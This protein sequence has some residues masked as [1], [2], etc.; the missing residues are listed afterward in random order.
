MTGLYIFNVD[1]SI[2]SNF[3]FINDIKKFYT[4]K[5]LIVEKTLTKYFFQAQTIENIS[6]ENQD[7]KKY[8]LLYAQKNLELTKIKDVHEELKNYKSDL[9]LAKVLSYV[10]FDDFTKVWLDVKKTDSKIEGLISENYAAGI[11]VNKGN[12]ALALLNG[13][14]KSN[15]AVFIGENKAPGITH[16]LSNSNTLLAKFIPIWINIKV[17]DEVIT[18]GM[19]NIFFEGLKVGKVVAIKKM[20]DMQ[21][22]KIEPFV[23]AL[24]QNFFYIYSKKPVVKVIEKTTTKP[25]V[26]PV[27][28]TKA[29]SK[30]P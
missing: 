9:K 21:E 10:D 23:N 18:S 19:D 2:S 1:Q 25:L 22:A 14:E 5:L 12:Q 27:K 8:R 16:G 17:G 28:T 7:L 6:L 30:K 29:T 26:K 24:E 11:V 4:E 20:A 13:N 15:Y 3:K